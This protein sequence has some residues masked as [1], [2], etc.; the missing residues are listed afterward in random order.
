M[1]QW[2]CHFQVF[3]EGESRVPPYVTILVLRMLWHGTEI[4]ERD[5][6]VGHS[7]RQ[8]ADRVIGVWP[9]DIFGNLVEGVSGVCW[10][11]WIVLSAIGLEVM[12]VTMTTVLLV[13]RECIEESF[14]GDLNEKETEEDDES[15]FQ[16]TRPASSR[17][18]QRW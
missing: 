15:T 16:D 7:F 5:G 9:G 8:V 6:R 2:K 12:L 17:I 3:D 14:E 18:V 10:V 1:Q 13:S 4:I 11:E